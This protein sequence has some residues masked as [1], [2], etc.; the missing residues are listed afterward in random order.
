LWLGKQQ[1]GVDF[2]QHAT[3]CDALC[4][5]TPQQIAELKEFA[6]AIPVKY[7][8]GTEDSKLEDS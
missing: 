2:S 1:A 5:P 3:K 7:N 6:L 4:S 8:P